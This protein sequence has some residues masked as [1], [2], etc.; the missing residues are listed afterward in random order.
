MKKRI[1]GALGAVAIATLAMSGCASDPLSPTETTGPAESSAPA[2]LTKISVVVAPIHFEPAYIADREGFFAE[3]GL[4]VEIIPGGAPTANIARAVSGEVDITTGSLGTLVTSAAQGVPVIGIAGNGYTSPDNATS[5]VLALKSS[6]IETPGDLAGR[7]VG[8]QG[9]NTGSEIP[10]F[11]AAEAHG[12]D[13]LSIERVEIA[14]A[15]METALVE[16][17]VDAVLASAPQYNQILARDD[18]H[19]VSNPS[20]E[21]MAGTPVTV[22]VVSTDWLA[23]NADTASAFVRA[24]EKA[25]A[26]YEDPANLDAILDITAEISQVDRANLSANSLIPVSVAF[27]LKQS[28]VQADGFYTFGIISKAV[29]I[30]DILWSEAPRR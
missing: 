26:F 17:T 9:L 2:E 15:G 21:Y 3:E 19:L 6:G 14:S 13:P 5:G 23:D 10:L 22:W 12:I 27:D 30:D 16:G 28:N 18:V 1:F 7:T 29:N 11:L 8:I 25:Q 4:E 20:T 24:M